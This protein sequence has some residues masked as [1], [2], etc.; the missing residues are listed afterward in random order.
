MEGAE[1]GLFCPRLAMDKKERIATLCLES[2]P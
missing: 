1:E 2:I